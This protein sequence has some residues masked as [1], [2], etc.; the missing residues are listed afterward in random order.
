[1]MLEQQFI[2]DTEIEANE[3]VEVTH[4]KKEKELSQKQIEHID[5]IRV[6]A[7]E[8]KREIKLKKHNEYE[9]KA[10]K[11]VVIE[12]PVKPPEPEPIKQDVNPVLSTAECTPVQS[13]A[14]VKK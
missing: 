12:E 2:K 11:A 5:N 4:P 10:K 3:N 6:I 8:K 7:L 13:A 1:M 14:V 9:N